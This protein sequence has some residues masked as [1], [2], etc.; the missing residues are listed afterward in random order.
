MYL[1]ALKSVPEQLYEAAA[2]DGAGGWQAFRSVTWPLLA[3]ITTILLAF[4]SIFTLTDFQL[5]W[6][7]T[8]GGPTDAT[9]VFTTLA[10]QR[11]IIAGQLGE[12]AAIAVSPIVLLIVLAFFV[13]RSVREH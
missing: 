4:S 7:I 9:Q 8:H 1:A 10:Y 3:P 6:T 12:G 2:I 11:G 5:I 13:V